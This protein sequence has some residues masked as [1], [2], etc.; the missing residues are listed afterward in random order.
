MFIKLSILL[1]YLRICTKGGITMACKAAIVFVGLYSVANFFLGLFTCWPIA[2]F[3]DQSLP[4]G[5][6]VNESAL[7]FSNAGINITTDL[8]IL[9]LPLFIL[10]GLMLPMRTKIVVTLILSLGG[11]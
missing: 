10:K 4:G 11:L 3:W 9:V 2:F 5:K 8:V 6:C 1:Q 7:W